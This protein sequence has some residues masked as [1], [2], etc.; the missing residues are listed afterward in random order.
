MQLVRVVDSYGRQLFLDVISPSTDPAGL[1][2]RHRAVNDPLAVLMSD[3]QVERLDQLSPMIP[4]SQAVR[5]DPDKVSPSWTLVYRDLAEWAVLYYRVTRSDWG[6]HTLLVR[7]GLLRSK[8]FRGTLFTRM[9]ELMLQAI[10]RHRRDGIR[11][12]MVGI[13]KHSQVLSRYRLAM[14]LQRALPAGQARFVPVPRELERKVYKWEEFAR[15]TEDQTTGEAAKFVIGAMFLVRF[16]EGMH[17]P[18]WA[19][20]ILERQVG[21]ASEILGYLLADAVAGFP[22]PFYPQ[23]LQ[24]AHEHAQVVDFDLDV[25]Q[26]TVLDSARALIEPERRAVFD[27]LRLAPDVSNRR[28]D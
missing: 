25:L 10:E 1:M 17:D 20:D 6:S 7:D 13:A 9:Y 19:I 16:G 24:Q 12:F 22:V 11:L 14:A 18:V 23:C 26:D 2:Q 15:G 3:L 27:A 28:Y 4:T 8:I 21:E 5:D